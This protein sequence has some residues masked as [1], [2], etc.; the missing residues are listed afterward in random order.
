LEFYDVDSGLEYL[1]GYSDPQNEKQ[2]PD[3]VLVDLNIPKKS[4]WEFIEELKHMQLGN[5][6]PKVYIVSNTQ[7]P[8]DK[9]RA[10]EIDEV[11]GLKAKFL[12]KEFFENF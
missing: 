3:L 11:I 9:Q 1:K 5:Q 12:T 4:G 8:E 2:I 10:A 6:L 7:N